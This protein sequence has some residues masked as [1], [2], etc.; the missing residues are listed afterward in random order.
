MRTDPVLEE[1]YQVRAQI[2]QKE[3]GFEQY[4][5]HR[6]DNQRI[7]EQQHPEVKWADF[8]RQGNDAL[9]RAA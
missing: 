7:Y 2:M 1:L 6:M 5:K 8:S 3:G 9:G 4:I